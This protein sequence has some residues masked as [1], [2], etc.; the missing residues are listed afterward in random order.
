[1][2]FLL[3]HDR[4]AFLLKYAEGVVTRLGE[5]ETSTLARLELKELGATRAFLVRTGEMNEMTAGW[6]YV[7]HDGGIKLVSNVANLYDLAIDWDTKRICLVV[8]EGGERHLVVKEFR[9]S[10]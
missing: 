2:V 10:P 4:R 1:M 7:V 8:W 9:L 3:H 5:F 6:L